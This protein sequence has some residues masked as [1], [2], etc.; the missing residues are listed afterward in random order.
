MTGPRDPDEWLTQPNDSSYDSDRD[1]SWDT[2]RDR[3]WDDSA[4]PRRDWPEQQATEQQSV[5]QPAG[6]LP[7]VE[8]GDAAA[9]VQAGPEWDIRKLG[10]RRRAT[11]AEQAVPWL[12]AII[13]ALAGM[14]IVLLA[15]IFTSENGTGLPEP[16]GVGLV[17]GHQPSG[18]LMPSLQPSVTPSAVAPTPS[19]SQAPTATPT[20][21]PSYPP[22]EMTYLSRNAATSPIYLFRRDFAKKV[23]AN[24]IAQ[25]DQGIASFAWAPDGTVGAALI[26][27][28]VGR[29]VAIEAKSSKRALIDGAS[30][31]TFG[32]DAATL[33]A[34]KIT[35]AGGKD[36]AQVLAVDYASGKAKALTS[37][38]YPHP[39]IFRDPL[40]TE[41][42]FTDDGGTVRMWP[43]TDGNLVL[44]I[45]GAPATYRV[46]P[47]DGTLSEVTRQPTLWSPDGKRRVATKLA[48]GTT[49]LTL[50]NRDDVPQASV[51]VNGLVSHLRWSADN[52][53]V[54]FTLGR[55]GHNGG[56][57]QDLYIWEL[58]DGKAP[59]PITSNGTSFGAEWMGA[60][61]SWEP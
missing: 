10:E 17:D 8:T 54:V 61:Q 30:E 34:V 35:T 12:I 3:G 48:N 56:V 29:V 41:A 13:L 9:S 47:M 46:D 33:Y 49:T 59:L 21:A 19:E 15:L 18:S 45:L 51:K 28:S 2:G 53:E 1:S 36:T 57:I 25:A 14:V 52:S 6:E 31:I 44:W 43:T 40:L 16:S 4:W 27:G 26:G 11:T 55:L 60:A 38:S 20:P 22:L 39:Q 42:A 7:A 32:Q 24:D 37:F 23:E 58:Q 50:M 5:E